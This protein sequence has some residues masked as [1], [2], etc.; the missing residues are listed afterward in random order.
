V[1]KSKK[2]EAS[3]EVGDPVVGERLAAIR[4]R[5]GLTQT[6]LANRINVSRQHISN[7][8]T[9]FTSPTLRVLTG[10]LETCG[11]SLPEFFYGPLPTDQTPKQ[12]EYHRR[13]QTILEDPSAS[14]AIQKVLDSFITSME[15]TARS[16]VQPVRA[17]M[18]H[19]RQH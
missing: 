9:G 7:I 1:K 3:S 16:V 2:P 13:L 6:E 10:F 11:V 18:R 15:A 8:E 14:S 19:S 5:A 4:L 12:R 17:Q